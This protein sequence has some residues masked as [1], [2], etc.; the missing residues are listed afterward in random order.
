MKK[1]FQERNLHSES[2]NVTP[3][4]CSRGHLMLVTRPPISARPW[5]CDRLE[6]SDNDDRPVQVGPRQAVVL[7]RIQ[8]RIKK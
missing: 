3:F 6:C 7:Y 2:V 4:L 1:R 5:N 8:R